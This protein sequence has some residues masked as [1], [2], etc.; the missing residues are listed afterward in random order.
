[1][2]KI[3]SLAF[4]LIVLSVQAQ[5]ISI[6]DASQSPYTG[7]GGALLDTGLNPGPYGNNENFTFT[8]CPEAPETITS[9]YSPFFDLGA[10]DEIVIYDGDNTGAPVLGTYTG[11]DLQ[12]QSVVASE[13]N[14]SGCLTVQ[15]T[16]DAAETGNFAFVFD[17]GPPCERPFSV[18]TTDQEVPH[19]IC[20]GDEVDFS[21]A[22]TIVAD[23]ATIAT[24]E[25]NFDDG[26]GFIDGGETISHVFEETGIYLVQV[27]I[28]DD[29]DCGNANRAD[30]RVE[31]SNEPIFL[32]DQSNLSLCIGETVELTNGAIPQ[33]YVDA[34]GANL[35][36]DLFIPDDQTTCFSS[37][38]IFGAFE[39]GA[40][41]DEVSDI[42]NFYINF[43]HSYMG[44]LVITFICPDGSAMA[45]H[46]Q[47]GGGTYLGIPVDDESDTPG[48]GF[49]YFWA[50]D[51]TNGTW[52][53]ESGGTLPAGTYSSTQPF[54]NLIGCPLNGIWTIEICDLFGIDNGFIFDWTVNIS[55]ENYPEA[56]SFTPSFGAGCDSTFWASGPFITDTSEDCNTISVFT[57]ET[58]VFEYTYE[59]T[60]NFGCTYVN[61]INL[62]VLEPFDPGLGASTIQCE[63]ATN[64]QLFNILN[65]DPDS[66]GIWTNPSDGVVPNGLF[67]GSMEEGDYTYTVSGPGSCPESSASV[68]VEVA[69]LG[70]PGQNGTIYL[71]EE[72]DSANLFELL[73]GA[74]A[75]G[76]WSGPGGAAFDGVFDPGT[77]DE[78][79][80]SYTVPS[81]NPCPAVSADVLT[82]I[83]P[84]PIPNIDPVYFYCGTPLV[85]DA[86]ITNEVP[87]V[88]YTYSWE[89]GAAEGTT[90]TLNNVTE[91]TE[92]IVSAF[93]DDFPECSNTVSTFVQVPQAPDPGNP[94]V[95]CLGEPLVAALQNEVWDYTYNWT[96]TNLEEPPQTS[97]I[98][99]GQGIEADSLGFYTLTIQENICGYEATQEYS[100][101]VCEIIIPNVFTPFDQ[102]GLNDAF[103]IVGVDAFPGSELIVYNRWGGIVFESDNYGSG[104]YWRPREDEASDGTYYYTLTI[105][106]P[107]GGTSEFSGTVTILSRP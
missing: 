32:A 57:E 1:M 67:S 31:V 59:A 72:S 41:V 13:T 107:G 87:G 36:G 48:V 49:D 24:Y 5:E 54:E 103:V 25:W 70:N 71:C 51:A 69:E 20:P 27:N 16:S 50:P 21:A 42:E 55:P 105:K 100:T 47:G 74:D 61:T 28:T 66:G 65:G 102:D 19:R 3:L 99:E 82:I 35:G 53:E 81:E 29:N 76:T 18:I 98:S 75:G 11:I 43:E 94:A 40:V 39:A 64:V 89:N 38:I 78:G 91:A 73:D 106:K 34:P 56:A 60:N 12:N 68:M 58:G 92:I 14:T 46:Q 77:D 37:E 33:T 90:Y 26:S 10:G 7:C 104:S 80:Y 30:F 85:L 97:F 44:D 17:C 15:F 88:G 8:V 9:L 83:V 22:E 63:S 93:L 6:S 95:V 96:Y 101:E 23:G 62:E 2:K 79:T 4:A 84:S 45:V 86:Q 52:S